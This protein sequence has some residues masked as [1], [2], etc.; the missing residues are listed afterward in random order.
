MYQGA[1]HGILF[2]GNSALD[3]LA[4]VDTFVFDKPAP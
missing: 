1:K 3:S 4:Q 2:R